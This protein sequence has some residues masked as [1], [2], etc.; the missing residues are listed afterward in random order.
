MRALA[1]LVALALWLGSAAGVAAAAPSRAASRHAAATR[2]AAPAHSE[3][4]KSV[5][6]QA[7]DAR[8]A[9]ETGSYGLAAM[10]LRAVR[11]RTT[12]DADLELALALDEARSGQPDSAWARLSGRLLMTAALDTGTI[13]R[14]R[15]YPFQRE[16]MWLNGTFDGWYWYLARAR[17]EVALHLR[18]WSDA[19]EAAMVAVKARPFSGRDH[20]LAAIAAGRAGDDAVARHEAALAAQLDPLLPEARYLDG[21]H[22]WR[23]GDHAGAIRA[24]HLAIG[25]DSSYRAPALAL[26]RLRIP[27]IRPDTLP[28]RF[29]T[30]VRATMMLTSPLRPKLEE[31]TQNDV[32]AA[33]YGV[34]Q[35]TLADSVK[36]IMRLKKPL[37][38]FVTVLVDENGRPVA[39]DLPWISPG[40]LPAEAVTQVLA[41]AARWRFR[42]ATKL[43]HNVRSFATVELTLQ[44]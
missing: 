39:D 34:P 30:G 2:P 1:G 18:R 21:L 28:V 25:I 15:D 23:G 12:P 10:T 41:A 22:A 36:A 14:R 37:Q 6:Q 17:A 8:V 38:L 4:L 3:M 26:A 35:V 44:P 42:P 11:A 32:L 31:F 33:L 29:L 7:S 20:L 13:A 9:E 27:G 43:S 40:Q 5:A 16:P 19:Y 24:F